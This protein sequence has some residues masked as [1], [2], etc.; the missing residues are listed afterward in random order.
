[1]VNL[2][3]YILNEWIWGNSPSLLTPS[4]VLFHA[5]A[6]A[7][8]EMGR[9]QPSVTCLSYQGTTGRPKGATLSH[10]NIVNNSNIIGE[11]LKLHLKVRRCWP[12]LTGTLQAWGG[13]LAGLALLARGTSFWGFWLQDRPSL[14]PPSLDSR[15]IA[16]NPAQPPV[17]L[18]GFCGGHNGKHDA[19]C[20]PHPVLSDL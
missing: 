10:Y 6:Q 16:V 18:P 14:L 12:R 17:P 1:M 15:T 9:K 3:E 19:R 20:H 8:K 4:P 5:E 7:R 11:H 2:Y 13:G